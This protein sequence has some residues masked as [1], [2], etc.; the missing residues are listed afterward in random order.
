MIIWAMSG[1]EHFA[2]NFNCKYIFL[3]ISNEYKG[4]KI[5]RYTYNAY[6][7]YLL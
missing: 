3:I 5:A 4:E 6:M 7:Q 2:F 1:N